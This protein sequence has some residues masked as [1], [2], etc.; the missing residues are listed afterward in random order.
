VGGLKN[1]TGREV[2]DDLAL[3]NIPPAPFSMVHLPSSRDITVLE[4]AGR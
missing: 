4:H 1:A 3:G 2:S